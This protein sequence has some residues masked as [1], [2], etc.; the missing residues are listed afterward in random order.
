MV[1]IAV[2]RRFGWILQVV[3]VG[4]VPSICFLYHSLR[5]PS[6]ESLG[7][8][9]NVAAGTEPGPPRLFQFSVRKYGM[10]C[11]NRGDWAARSH[12]QKSP[13]LRVSVRL[14]LS[15]AIGYRRTLEE[16]VSRSGYNGRVI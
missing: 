12:P 1:K 10:L 15:N 3:R 16:A 4:S 8:D 2:L 5:H 13:C 11:V 7:T 6:M 9:P 14:R